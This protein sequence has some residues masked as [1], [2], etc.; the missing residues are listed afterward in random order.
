M[1]KNGLA[2][3]QHQ[4]NITTILDFIGRVRVLFIK[5]SLVKEK[6]KSSLV[7][8]DIIDQKKKTVFDEM[9]VQAT[10]GTTQC[11]KCFCFQSIDMIWLNVRLQRP[12]VCG[13]VE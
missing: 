6:H 4:H 2:Q 7:Y 3:I 10:M 9:S 13:H 5:S 8:K 12:P 1:T 11:S